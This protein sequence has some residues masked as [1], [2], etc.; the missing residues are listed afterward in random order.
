MLLHFVVALHCE[1]APIIEFYK[2]KS[3]HNTLPQVYRNESVCL[4]VTGI[5]GL[6]C[7]SAVGYLAGLL[8]SDKC[9]VW[10]N[11]GIAG[12]Q[13]F[14]RGTVCLVRKV[15]EL[16]TG[17]AIYPSLPFSTRIPRADCFYVDRAEVQFNENGLYEMESFAFFKA[18]WRFCTIDYVHSIKVVSDNRLETADQITH[19]IISSLVGSQ[20]E[21]VDRN[22]VVPLCCIVENL[23]SET[24][25][26]D[27]ELYTDKWHFSE[28]NRLRL[29]RIL[30]QFAALTDNQLPNIEDYKHCNKA[31]EFLNDVESNL[32]C[33]EMRLI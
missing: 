31:T 27:I 14:S 4:V 33:C 19:S 26:F 29:S 5:G 2:L 13:Q 11:I 1:A 22:L 28:T 8:K 18:A 10:I 7:A 3:I 24:S 17:K 15:T 20:L 12:H 21:M 6:A 32:Q 16:A 25:Q 23:R 9:G 30:R